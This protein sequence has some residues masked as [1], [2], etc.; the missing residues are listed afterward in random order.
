MIEINM[1][2]KINSKIEKQKKILECLVREKIF[3]QVLTHQGSILTLVYPL[4]TNTEH[5]RSKD[6]INPFVYTKTI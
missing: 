5:N 1:K 6:K 2:K 3:S 4:Y